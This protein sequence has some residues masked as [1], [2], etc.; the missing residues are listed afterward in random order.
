MNQLSDLSNSFELTIKDTDLQDVTSEIAETFTDE[1]LSEGVLKEIPIISTIIGLARVVFSLQETLLV[2][3]LVYFISGIHDVDLAKRKRMIS[4]ID[5]SQEYQIKVGE[6]LLYIIDKCE[7][8]VSAIYHSQLFKAFLEEKI[9]YLEF[10]R[11]SAVIQRIFIHDLEEFIDQYDIERDIDPRYDRFSEFDYRLINAGICYLL[12]DSV[13]IRDQDDWE[14]SDK[15]IVEGGKEY[16]NI[17]EIGSILRLH[18][19]KYQ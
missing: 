15:Y 12:T 5:D 6:K 14:S 2:K 9:T 19:M 1:L 3:K 4:K 13:S 16:L 10:L 7:D 17:T 18:L 11:G 8:H